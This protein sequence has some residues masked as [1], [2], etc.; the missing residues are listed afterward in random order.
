MCEPADIPTRRLAEHDELLRLL[1][2]HAVC[3]DVAT[4]GVA[5]WI[6]RSALADGHL[7]RAMGLPNREALRYLF[8]T[9]FPGLAAL[10]DRDM[11]WKR[12][13]YKMLCGWP[14]FGG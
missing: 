3:D 13:L 12:F 11:R 2:S 7:W 6:A 14:G 8:E 1:M 5:A 4:R 9:R 10:N